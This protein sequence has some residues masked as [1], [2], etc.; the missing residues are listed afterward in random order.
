MKE[1]GLKDDLAQALVDAPGHLI[2]YIGG[3]IV[4]LLG[5]YVIITLA[6]F[7]VLLGFAV[8][9]ALIGA[10][11]FYGGFFLMRLV[12]NIADAIGFVGRGMANQS[13]ATNQ[14]AAV[15]NADR[16]NASQI[17][18]QSDPQTPTPVR[19]PSE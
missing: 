16:L 11:A 5:D 1:R 4:L 12:A 14:I 9:S 6:I 13:M 18:E 7:S 10:A 19:H 15:L 8:S 3:L 2:R 17:S